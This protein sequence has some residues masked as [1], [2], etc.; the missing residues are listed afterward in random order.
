V[1]KIGVGITGDHHCYRLVSLI[2]V[3]LAMLGYRHLNWRLAQVWAWWLSKGMGLS[4]TTKGRENL[5]PGQSYILVP[6]HQGNADIVALCLVLEIPSRWVAKESLL[7]IPFLGWAIAATG[8]IS[9]NRSDTSQAIGQLRKGTEILKDGCSVLIYPEGTRTSDGNLQP[10]KKGAFRMA[11]STGVPILPITTNGAFQLMPRGTINVRSGHVTVTFG[12]PI[13][14]KG[15][16]DDDLPWLM[17]KTRDAMLKNLDL[18]YD[19]FQTKKIR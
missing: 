9:I 17:E 11:I 7:R 4:V 5:A 19:P 2:M 10:F 1:A 16:T 6:N 18:N 12:E 13:E 15:L 8:A 3:S 14:T